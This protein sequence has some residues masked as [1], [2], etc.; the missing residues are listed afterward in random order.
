MEFPKFGKIH[1]LSRDM[2]ITEKLD[3]TN[4]SIHITEKGEFLVG[5]RT[6]FITPDNDNFGFAAWA[7]EHEEELRQLGEGS[8]YGEW[9]GRKIQRGYDL[10]ERRFSLFNTSRW[11]EE[12]KPDCCHVVPVLYIGEFDTDMVDYLLEGLHNGGSVAAP[13]FGNPEGV[14]VYHR[15]SNSL[16]KKTLDHN[17]E[18][19]FMHAKNPRK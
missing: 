9:W 13:G 4:A 3:G 8:H 18:H 5:S 1:R 16:F 10:D 15:H 12:T 17:D 7:Y 6:R 11:N 19:K 2:V 14:V